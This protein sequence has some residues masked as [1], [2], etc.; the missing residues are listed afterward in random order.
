M[1]STLVTRNIIHV[2]QQWFHSCSWSI[3][4][5]IKWRVLNLGSKSKKAYYEIF[6]IYFIKKEIKES[7]T[8]T[9]SFLVL[10][11]K[12][13]NS[14]TTFAFSSIKFSKGAKL[15]L[16]LNFQLMNM[17]KFNASFNNQWP[18][19][20]FEIQTNTI[21]PKKWIIIWDVCHVNGSDILDHPHIIFLVVK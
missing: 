13:Y 11:D 8:S 19:H 15:I 9:F 17:T 2:P 12:Y 10:E 1:S 5:N 20:W 16:S 3:N 18:L 7:K 6:K 21:A 4:V 14:K